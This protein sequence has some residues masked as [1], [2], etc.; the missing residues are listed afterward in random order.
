MQFS[1]VYHIM[2]RKSKV[3]SFYSMKV[4]GAELQVQSFL[5]TALRGDKW[6]TSC[7]SQFTLRKNPQYPLNKKVGGPYSWSGHSGEEKN[8]T[9]LPRF[10]LWI[11]QPTA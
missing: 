7:P 5:A 3:F 10:Q 9:S 8:L 6:S 2:S 4:G 11:L 1:K